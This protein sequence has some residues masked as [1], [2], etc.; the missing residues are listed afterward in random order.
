M[1]A[2][3]ARPIPTHSQELKVTRLGPRWCREAMASILPGAM[4]S[5]PLEE[6]GARL[7]IGKQGADGL[8]R[9]DDP[10]PFCSGLCRHGCRTCGGSRCLSG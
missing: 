8:R 1:G 2:D 10:P 4:P 6:L 5:Q 9:P 7:T 3:G